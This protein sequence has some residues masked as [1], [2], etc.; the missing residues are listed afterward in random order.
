MSGL[1]HGTFAVNGIRIHYAEQ[2]A[3]H[4]ILF[5]HGFPEYWG[6]WRHLMAA[7]SNRFRTVAIDTRGINESE[8]PAPVEAYTVDNLVEDV[9]QVIM[10]L[11]A[12]KV[13]LVGH[14]WG[15]F[16]AWD[17]AIRHPELID[18]LVIFNAGHPGIFDRLLRE[19]PTQ[20]AHSKYM[21]A[22]RSARGEELL[23]RDNFGT[24]RREILEPHIARGTISEAEAAEYLAIWHRPGNLTA[25]L[26]YYRANKIGPANGDDAPPRIIK[27]TIVKVPTLVIW[28]EKDP[29]FSLENLDLL[30]EVVPDLIVRRFPDN[31]HWIVHQRGPEAAALIAS[32]IDGT[33][34]H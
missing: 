27:D 24:F 7:L 30:P 13:T 5:V 18:R 3:G 19:S 31:D 16:I 10:A 1:K 20:Q 25:G 29:Y 17:T 22:F 32:F 4:V 15:G 6:A 11:G 33:L 8:A 9:R 14:D 2:G 26:N 12:A 28:G 23:S 34:E 21:L